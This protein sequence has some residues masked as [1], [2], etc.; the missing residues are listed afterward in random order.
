LLEEKSL[1]VSSVAVPSVANAPKIGPRREEAQVTLSG[2]VGAPVS[3][4]ATTSDGLGFTGRGE[5][6]LAIATAVLRRK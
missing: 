3:I 6:L 2:L 1:Q 5:G 4:S